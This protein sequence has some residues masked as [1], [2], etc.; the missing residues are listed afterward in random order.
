MWKRHLHQSAATNQSAATELD[1]T[2][3]KATAHYTISAVRLTDSGSEIKQRVY[4]V[5]AV[6]FQIQCRLL[7]RSPLSL[8]KHCINNSKSIKILSKIWFSVENLSMI[9]A[10][11]Q[12]INGKDVK[13]LCLSY[14]ILKFQRKSTRDKWATAPRTLPCQFQILTKFNSH[15][16]NT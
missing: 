7:K 6:W 4:F 2:S 9:P 13:P 14:N 15:R 5:G 12:K 3:L 11:D 10:S 1:P 8:Y 16:H